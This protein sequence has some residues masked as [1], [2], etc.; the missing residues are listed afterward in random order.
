MKI[1]KLIS[2][3]LAIIAIATIE[4]YALTQGIDGALLA[5]TIAIIAGLGGYEAKALAST[6]T[7]W[8]RRK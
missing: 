8:R 3:S 6:I 1:A 4:L 7:A 5:G 2:S